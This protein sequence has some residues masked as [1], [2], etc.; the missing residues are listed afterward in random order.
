[1]SEESTIEVDADKLSDGVIEDLVEEG[2][3]DEEEAEELGDE[4]WFE[5]VDVGDPNKTGA[6][7]YLEARYENGVEIA[8]LIKRLFVDWKTTRA[9]VE[10]VERSYS[11][12][13]KISVS[14]ERINGVDSFVLD[15]D[16]DVLANLMLYKNVSNPKDLVGCKLLVLPESFD[17]RSVTVLVPHN[18]SV[19]GQLRFK[20]YSL[21]Q[22]VREKTYSSFISN[23]EKGSADALLGA[24]MFSAFVAI[25][26]VI[27][28]SASEII[29]NLLM[30]PLAICLF[31]LLFVVVYGLTRI[32]LWGAMVLFRSDFEEL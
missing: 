29:G 18:V 30:L 11:D 5:E 8:G 9:E 17:H 1:M 25:F 21:V 2:G 13:I 12:D 7:S 27:A 24:T 10:S 26:G 16:S 23:S 15:P 19:T 32:V 22:E 14:H 28:G 4:V 3:L 6:L 31:I 20:L